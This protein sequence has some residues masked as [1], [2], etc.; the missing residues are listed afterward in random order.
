MYLLFKSFIIKLILR[1]RGA[2]IEKNFTCRSYPIIDSDKFFI[3]LTISKNVIIRNNVEFY[4]RKNGKIFINNQVKI[5]SGVRLLSSNNS[6]LIINEDTKIGKNST[7]NSGANIL[8]GKKCLISANC[9]VQSS[10]HVFKSKKN[11]Q[12]LGYVNKE[13]NIEDDVWIGANSV[14]LKGVTVKRGTVV[15]ALSKLNTD[16]EEYSIY[17]GNPAIKLKERE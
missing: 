17:S 10:S 3:K 13:I 15:G 14:I 5:D 11:I 8:I 16:T 1:L 7:I 12:D 6:D 2:K 9:I 4:F